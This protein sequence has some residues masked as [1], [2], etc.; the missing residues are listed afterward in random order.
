VFVIVRA[1]ARTY[2]SGSGNSKGNGKSKGNSK[3]RSRLPEGMTE[4]KQGQLQQ[5]KKK[6]IPAG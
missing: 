5:Q 4:R 2:L 1:E 3:R 6:Q